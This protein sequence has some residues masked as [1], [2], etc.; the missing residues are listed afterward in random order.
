MY[1]KANENGE[2]IQAAAVGAIPDGTEINLA[3][4]IIDESG[5]LIL[6]TAKIQA[7]HNAIRKDEILQRLSEIDAE[8]I[9]PLRAVLTKTSSEFDA[10]KLEALESEA[11]NLREE[12][13]K[14]EGLNNE[15]MD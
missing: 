12:L 2:I 11:S 10:E 13:V 15:N 7:Q 8:S 3:N 6:N 5:N 14:L 9:R 4:Y 1:I